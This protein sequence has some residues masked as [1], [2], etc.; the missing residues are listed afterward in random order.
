MPSERISVSLFSECEELIENSR[1]ERKGTCTSQDGPV[2]N[3]IT[4]TVQQN[5]PCGF[6]CHSNEISTSKPGMEIEQRDMQFSI[7]KN[8]GKKIRSTSQVLDTTVSTFVA[9]LLK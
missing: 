6:N 5:E 7:R 2:S 1:E 3:K 8:R 9:V 4:N